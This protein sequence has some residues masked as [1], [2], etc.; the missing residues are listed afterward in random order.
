MNEALRS[1]AQVMQGA[2]G[3][4]ALRRLQFAFAGAS[5]AR[6][7]GIVVLS[8]YAY[9]VSGPSA[10]GLVALAWMLP[11]ALLAPF[12]T[13]LADRFPRRDVLVTSAVL[14]AASGFAIAAAVLGGLPLAAVVAFAVVQGVATTPYRPAQAALLP[15]LASTPQQMAAA[16]AVWHGI[17]SVGFV[18]GALVGGWAIAALAPAL[19][20]ALIALPF[21][22]SAALL[23][24][25]PRDPRPAYSAPIRGSRVRDEALRGYRAV[26]REPQLRTLIGLLTASKLVEGAVDT[27]VVLVAL[28]LLGLGDAAVGYLNAAWGIGGIIGMAVTLGLL[29]RGNLASGLGVGCLAIGLPLVALAGLATAAM[30]VAALFVLGVGYA[31]VEIAGETLMQRLAPDEVLARVFGVLETTYTASMGIGAAL[32]PPLAAAAGIR[33][34]LLIVGLSLPLLAVV[35]WRT[36]ARYE[37]GTAIPE[38][39]FALL[40]GVPLFAPLPVASVENL[41]LRLDAVAVSAGEEIIVQGETGD[42]FYVIGEGEVEILV[43][44]RRVRTQTSGDYFGEIALLQDSPR[45]ATVR[46]LGTGLL[47]ALESEEFVASVTGNLRSFQAAG[48]VIGARLHGPPEP[49]AA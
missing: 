16:N 49:D 31:L 22:V 37:S 46:A 23:T 32:A 21:A 33:G 25:I 11:A 7:A 8:V 26:L 12:T 45:T 43:D 2:F 40:R 29:H 6:W 10:V 4:P 39:P 17:E 15:Q 13:M 47:Y 38:R 41:A 1:I 24:G 35:R 3:T 9:N 28:D 48:E 20:F 30:A 14:R 18:V 42:R 44:G 5:L 19:A 27:L 36:L 34:A